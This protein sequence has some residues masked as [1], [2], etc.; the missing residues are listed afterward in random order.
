MCWGLKSRS[1]SLPKALPEVTGSEALRMPSE[2]WG[3]TE[4]NWTKQNNKQKLKFCPESDPSTCIFVN[5]TQIESPGNREYKLRNCPTRLTCGQL[6]GTFSWWGLE[7]VVSNLQWVVL[8]VD[9][10]LSKK[11]AEQASEASQEAVFLQCIS[12][13]SCLQF[14]FWALVLGFFHDAQEYA[15]VGSISQRNPSFFLPHVCFG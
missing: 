12:S 15:S 11:V 7:L 6:H 3:K 8:S 14:S 2:Q 13:N 9:P 4:L 5:L 10:G 1:S